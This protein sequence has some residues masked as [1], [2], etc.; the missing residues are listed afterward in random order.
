M[1]HPLR[2]FFLTL[3]FIALIQPSALYADDKNPLRLAVSAN[4]GVPLKKIAE[5]FTEKTGTR[6]EIIIGSSGKLFAQITQGAPFDIFFSADSMRPLELETMGFVVDRG[7]FVYATGRLALLSALDFT[8]KTNLNKA[9]LSFLNFRF[10][11]DDKI[12]RIA[13]ANPDSAPYGKAAKEMLLSLGIYKEVEPKLIY[14]E[15]VSQAYAFMRSGNADIAIV[16]LSILKGVDA[17]FITIDQALHEPLVQEAAIIQGAHAAAR[18]FADFLSTEK[19]R[20][21][22]KVYGYGTEKRP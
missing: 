10:L 9:E 21:I 11:K 12:K 20:N 2:V 8:P 15:S 1:T 16:A 19:A 5:A 13:I 3:F 14:G 22:L 18:D 6:V 7:R 17:E 4:A